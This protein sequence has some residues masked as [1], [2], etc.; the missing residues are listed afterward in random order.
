MVPS[1][2]PSSWNSRIRRDRPI[3]NQTPTNR[4]AENADRFFAYSFMPMM[5]ERGVNRKRRTPPQ[6]FSWS[7]SGNSVQY[8]RQVSGIHHFCRLYTAQI[9][10]ATAYHPRFSDCQGPTQ[11]AAIHPMPLP[12]TIGSPPVRRHH[13]N[14]SK[15]RLQRDRHKFVHPRHRR[16]F[17]LRTAPR[18]TGRCSAFP[19][20]A[21]RRN[22][23]CS[24]N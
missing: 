12:S 23:P 24:T 20:P 8:N 9:P 21:P 2:W 3:P 16:F 14:T 22:S 7:L 6:V 10:R 15:N 13:K 18:C 11:P 1:P 4:F 17:L 19:S 5:G